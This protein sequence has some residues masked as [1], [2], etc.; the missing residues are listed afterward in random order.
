MSFLLGIFTNTFLIYL[1]L[2]RSPQ[3]LQSYRGVFLIGSL[4][5]NYCILTL[6]LS[7]TEICGPGLLIHRGLG[8]FFPVFGQWLL[9]ALMM[10]GISLEPLIM[11]FETWFRYQYLKTRNPLPTTT[12]LLQ[13]F[14]ILL[15]VFIQ[16]PAFVSGYFHETTTDYHQLLLKDNPDAV[17]LVFSGKQFKT[18]EWIAPY[19]S[20]LTFICFVL[21]IF[22][23]ILSVQVMKKESVSMSKKTRDLLSQFTKTLI[24]R[25]PMPFRCLQFN[26]QSSFLLAL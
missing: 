21:T 25:P 22:I 15:L 9:Y 14:V 4:G 24:T 7:Q 12:L 8:R 26:L 23:S 18:L 5:D 10:S 2:R 3:S 19:R 16:I 13:I 6:G 20:S 17:I 11:L 1:I